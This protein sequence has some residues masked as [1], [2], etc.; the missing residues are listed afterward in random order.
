MPTSVKVAFRPDLVNLEIARLTPLKKITPEM[1]EERKY[2]QIAASL[3][4]VGLLEPIVVFPAGRGKFL[5]LDG[6]KRLDI[7]KT[8]GV[9]E[10]R[11]LL[12]TDDES[13]TYNKRVN[14]LSPIGEHHMILKALAIGVTEER[15]AESL[16]VKVKAIRQKRALLDGICPEAAD[17]L[18]DKR[19]NAKALTALRRMK[20][21]RQIEAAGL[22]VAADR[23][24]HSFAIAL[25][26]GTRSEL[27]IAP[28][29]SFQPLRRADP[30]QRAMLEA[31]TENLL[32]EYKVIEESYGADVLTLSVCCGYVNRLLGNARVLRY[33]TKR[34]PEILLELQ[35][36]IA[37][38]QADKSQPRKMP[39][40]RATV[41]AK[42]RAQH[43]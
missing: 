6:H 13:Y 33:L 34:Y 14:Y 38:M 40:K 23:Y 10:V 3:T 24:S 21:S 12:A 37:H 42:A 28:D 31:E 36:L 8:R 16:D 11:C 26:A 4:H 15:I 5:V 19:I 30:S 22:M 41:S 7:L 27:L 9:T 18:N 20:P 17:I 29:R 43:A 1:R 2:G 25:L 39:V 32:R 35:K